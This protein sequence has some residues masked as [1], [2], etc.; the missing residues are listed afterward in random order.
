M[1]S[2]SEMLTE[3]KGGRMMKR[4]FRDITEA[5]ETV[6]F[7]FGRFNPSTIGHAA[8]IEKVASVAGSNPFFIYPSHTTGPKDPLAHSLKIAWMRKMFPKY[9]RNI[10][11]DK[12][13]KTAIQIAEKL[14]KDGY[15][16][17][18]M[19]AGSDRL[20][21]FSTLL[22]RYN[23]APDKK[24]KQL[25]K[26]DSVKVVSAGERDPDAEGLA[27]MSA[28]KLRVAAADGKFDDFKKGIPNTRSDD[29]KKKYYLAVRKGMGIREEREMS[30][31]YDSLRDAYLTGKIWNIGESVEANGVSGEVVRKGTNYLSF[32]SED[33]KV[34]KAWL[35][36]IE[37][38]EKKE[39]YAIATKS[40]KAKSGWRRVPDTRFETEKSAQ[41]YGMKY[42]TDK[43]GAKLFKVVTF[44]EEVE[45]DESIKVTFTRGKVAGDIKEYKNEYEA[46]RA[47]KELQRKGYEIR[48]VIDNKGNNITDRFVEEV[49]LDERNYAKEYA[50]YQGTPEQIAR[51]SSR[52]KA[53]RAMG[54]KAVKGQD[55]G[56]KDN[57]PLNNDPENLRNEDPSKN[58]REPRLR[59]KP[60]L[61]EMTWY[62]VALAKISQMSHPKGYE[63]MV[64]QYAADMKKPELKNKTASY[65]AA[66]I[67]SGYRGM[68]GRKLVQYINKLVDAGKLPKELK[69]ELHHE[70]FK[71]FV[72]RIQ[73]QE[74]LGSG[75][76]QKDYI[77]DFID[78]DAPQFAGK[79]KKERI[80]MA[81]AAF[82]SKNEEEG[83]CWDGYKQLGMKMKNG[84][85][86][87]NCVPEE[88]NEWGEITEAD[89]KSGKEL[90]NPTKGDVKKY[91]VYVKN[92]KGNVVKVEFGDPNMSIKRDDPK[93]RANFRARHNC[94]QKKDRT[95]AGYW[96]CKFW[97]T[98]SVTDLMKG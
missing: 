64:K 91:K 7:G 18:I 19:V 86:V 61:D 39:Y 13:A 50:N 6:V 48:S 38:G 74:V 31:D 11:A 75:A 55:V 70:S 37:L 80:A 52:N 77:D 28:S 30:D 43:Y 42:H 41:A 68:D 98:K 14:Y 45:L 5:K 88:F 4:S 46:K 9:K 24:G 49:E 84:K 54:D 83:P 33:G 21:E 25:F 90:N 20:K 69:A 62:K 72:D 95:T 94:D 53:R 97:S 8:L 17:L 22:N 79:S 60:E 78:S 96:S 56:H 89:A 76:S 16:N 81:I 36:E 26:F 67:A 1:M 65:I 66:T 3:D 73:V 27:G 40:S 82:R 58:R 59:E 23:D 92:D 57:N 63:K 51:R 35:H 32:V 87:P 34:H 85:Q 15:K 12:N 93:A 2:F 10:I 47:I 44:K 71:S 29:D